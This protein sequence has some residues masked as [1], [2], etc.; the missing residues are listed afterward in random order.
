[1]IVHPGALGDLI[2]AEPVL[3]GVRATWR[4]SGQPVLH[5]IDQSLEGFEQGVAPDV[6]YVT[7]DARGLYSG[8]ASARF[9]ILAGLARKIGRQAVGSAIVFKSSP[10]W[11]ALAR[12]CSRG[13]VVA[14]P[15][16][17]LGRILTTQRVPFKSGEHREERWIRLAEN[18]PGFEPTSLPK[19]VPW[20]SSDGE[21][22]LRFRQQLSTRRLWF[23]LAPGGARN[24]AGEMWQRRWPPRNYAAVAGSLLEVISD[25]GIVLLGGPG[26]IGEGNALVN[27]LPGQNGSVMNVVGKTSIEEARSLIGELR[28]L[29]THDSGLMH[30]GS[31][32]RTPVVAVFGPTNPN[33]ACPR[34]QGRVL[35]LW[36]PVTRVRPCHDEANGTVHCAAEP[37][38][39]ERI[40]PRDVVDQALRLLGRCGLVGNP[41]STGQ[42]SAQPC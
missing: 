30:L 40:A 13:E 32:T 3:S 38:C 15:R 34:W 8:R 11:I 20:P 22:L 21:T 7:F 39:I 36:N 31:T 18:L 23:G 5:V 16:D 4:R 37:C 2:Q 19:R 1:M 25:A 27:A 9:R 17:P 33:I 29:I 10:G 35:P 12:Y 6:R 42:D 26:D 14:I 24:S 41:S 28:L